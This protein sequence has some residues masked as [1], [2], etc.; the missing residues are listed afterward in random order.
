[1]LAEPCCREFTPESAFR[2]EIRIW[3]LFRDR[4]ISSRSEHASDLRERAWTVR[5][6][7]EDCD[8]EHV[9][10]RTRLERKVRRTGAKQVRVAQMSGVEAATRLTKHFL[11]KVEAKE[12]A[13]RADT[14]GRGDGVVTDTWSDLQSAIALAETEGIEHA[15]RAGHERAKRCFENSGIRVGESRGL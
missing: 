5:N 14:L 1:L 6:L 8:Q 10:K 9:V 2:H 12:T 11:L 7:T 13:S 3:K 15:P 4:D